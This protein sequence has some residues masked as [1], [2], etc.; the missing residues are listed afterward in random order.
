MVCLNLSAE[1]ACFHGSTKPSGFNASNYDVTKEWATVAAGEASIS[2]QIDGVATISF[3]D[4]TNSANGVARFDANL[5]RWYGGTKLTITP[6]DGVTITGITFN[7]TSKYGDIKTGEKTITTSSNA[8]I[9]NFQDLNTTQPVVFT[10]SAQIQFTHLEIEYT[11]DAGAV[12][13][14]DITSY[15]LEDATCNVTL[16]C[17]TE[18][19]TIYYGFSENEITT[20]YTAPFNVTENCTVYA[21]AQKG[22]DKS[23]TKSLEISLPYTSFAEVLSADLSKKDEVIIV[24]NFEVLYQSNDGKYL[25]LTD[26]TNNLLIYNPAD[27]FDKGL[28]ISKIEGTVEIYN[29][30]FEIKEAT[31]ST[32]GNGATYEVKDMTSFE[33]LN[34]DDNLFD[35]Y[36]F[37]GCTISGKSGNNATVA[38]G[39]ETIPMYNTFGINFENGE[40]YDI[41][42]FVWRNNDNLQIVPTTIEGGEFVETVKTPVIL[43]NKHELKEGDDVTITCATAGAV[44]YYTTDGTEPTQESTKYEG[45]IDFTSDFTIKAIAYYEG[46]DK[47]MLP[48]EIA[49]RSYHVF[50][51]YCNILDNSH[52]SSNAGSYV[53]HTCTVD[54]VDYAM[55]G[56]HDSTKGMQLNQTQFCYIIQTGDNVGLAIESIDVN[57]NN[58]SNDGVDLIVRASNTPFTDGLKDGDKPTALPSEITSNGVEIGKIDKANPELVFTKDYNYF[59]IYP[60]S[61]KTSKTV[62][63]L[64]SVTINYR[65]PAE[66]NMADVPEIDEN[67]FVLF[68]NSGLATDMLPYHEDWNAMYQINDGAETAFEDYA[69]DNDGIAL[70]FE[71]TLDEATLHTLKLWYEHYYHGTKAG[72]KEFYHLTDPKVAEAFEGG[73]VQFDFGKIGEGVK[74]YF[75]INGND[76]TIETTPAPAAVVRRAKTVNSVY[77]LDSEADKDATHA[78]TSATSTIEIDPTLIGEKY[79][80]KAQAYHADTNTLSEVVTKEGT[81]TVSIVELSGAKA[82]AEVYDLMGRKV[83]RPAHGIYI[84]GGVKVRL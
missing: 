67:F 42:A 29:N 6:A 74:V 46:D 22:E 65:E 76:P 19:A 43:P 77:T 31:I 59:A 2:N 51:P 20:E 56:I 37:K 16:S 12:E 75:T 36:T 70:D 69:E 68:D 71:E 52:D 10:N 83:Q 23:V 34:Y 25:I 35:L 14:V 4:A 45:E 73:K 44:I 72:E 53:R 3:T 32:G 48:S 58:N 47:T 54:D 17:A 78:I 61:A 33:G 84:Q 62:V 21:F 82:N 64:N 1:K 55:V 24:G 80:I 13:K 50:D 11:V 79:K 60:Y 30:L 63:Y 7:T 15:L 81:N 39:E 5:I 18:G 57:W 41:T 28:K 27:T 38:L 40:N 9:A 49:E 8:K 66:A 26:G